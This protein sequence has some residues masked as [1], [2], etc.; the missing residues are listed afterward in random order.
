[1]SP[2]PTVTLKPIGLKVWTV[3]STESSQ[4]G[5]EGGEGRG[6]GG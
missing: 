1:M 6:V 5:G 4:G 3:H 2:E